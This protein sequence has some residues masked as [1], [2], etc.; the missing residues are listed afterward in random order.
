ML[1]NDT[2]PLTSNADCGLLV[3]IHTHPAALAPFI[4]TLMM[5]VPALEDLKEVISLFHTKVL[6]FNAYALYPATKL[7]IAQ[8]IVLFCHP[9]ITELSKTQVIVLLLHQTILEKVA[10]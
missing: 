9:G 7:F 1:C 2:S 6:L 8:E 4:G 5:N 3:F 10:V